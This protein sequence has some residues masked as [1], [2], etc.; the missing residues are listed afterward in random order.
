MEMQEYSIESAYSKVIW[1][2]QISVE[3][4]NPLPTM[5]SFFRATFSCK[6]YG[7][8]WFIQE[9]NKTNLNN[10]RRLI[11]DME[12]KIT[13]YRKHF[14]VMWKTEWEGMRGKT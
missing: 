14:A 12:K 9:N 11:W 2:K 8:Q 1:W 4:I 6:Q 3:Q 7:K 10:T 13:K 5:R